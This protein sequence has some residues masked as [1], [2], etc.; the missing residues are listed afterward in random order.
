MLV[1]V[2]GGVAVGRD[3]GR[4]IVSVFLDRHRQI[5]PLRWDIA[6]QI[7]GLLNIKFRAGSVMYDGL[8][9]GSKVIVLLLVAEFPVEAPVDRKP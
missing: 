5:I 8:R 2:P 4:K 1:D 6:W 7:R 9:G 3:A